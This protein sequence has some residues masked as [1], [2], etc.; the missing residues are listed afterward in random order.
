[1]QYHPYIWAAHWSNGKRFDFGH[2]DA[3][4]FNHVAP[5]RTFTGGRPPQPPLS[6]D[7]NVGFSHH[8]FTNGRKNPNFNPG[9]IYNFP[10]DSRSFCPIR[11][12]HTIDFDLRSFVQQLPS[13]RCFRTNQANHFSIVGQ[14]SK[15]AGYYVAFFRMEACSAVQP[16]AVNLMIESAYIK[17]TL[18]IT[19]KGAY[20]EAFLAIVTRVLGI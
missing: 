15:K 19:G 17:P 13:K 16:Y 9:D 1:M 8:C 12:Q 10:S 11:Y 5:G 20:N 3:F 2:L 7:I 6:V 14:L 4:A 18:P